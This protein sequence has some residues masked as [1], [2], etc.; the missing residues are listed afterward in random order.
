MDVEAVTP[1]RLAGSIIALLVLVS[2]PSLEAQT[3]QEPRGAAWSLGPRVALGGSVPRWVLG[4]ICDSRSSY[5]LGLA[6]EWSPPAA[7]GWVT[8]ENEFLFLVPLPS[9]CVS[10]PLPP[11]G[12]RTE[13]ET[14]LAEP[15]VAPRSG[16]AVEVPFDPG[17]IRVEGGGA[18]FLNGLQPALTWGVGW[19]GRGEGWSLEVGL[20]W[21]RVW[22]GGDRVEVVWDEQGESRRRLGA[23]DERFEMR[24]V[25]ASLRWELGGHVARTAG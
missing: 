16:L 23:I 4:D 5:V 9:G 7:R 11:E 13:F 12:R 2:A 22:P 21:W 18:L 14:S 17:R 3:L 8:L 19:I 10:A 20:E 1:R 25:S 24:F 6:S 15:F